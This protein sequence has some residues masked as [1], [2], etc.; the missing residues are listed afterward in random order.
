MNVLRARKT[1]HDLQ[2]CEFDVD[3]IVVFAE[4][5]LDFML[6]DRWTPLDDQQDVAQS[7]ILNFGTQGE[8][9]DWMIRGLAERLLSKRSLSD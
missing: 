9:R 7:H 6:E 8:H 4:K 5:D 1:I 3:W 2:F